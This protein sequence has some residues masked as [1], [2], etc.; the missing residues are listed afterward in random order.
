MCV[1]KGEHRPF[2]PTPSTIGKTTARFRRIEKTNFNLC[3]IKHLLWLRTLFVVRF[4]LL[5]MCWIF[6]TN[7]MPLPKHTSM[8]LNKTTNTLFKK[9]IYNHMRFI[10]R[11][12]DYLFIFI[13]MTT[14]VFFFSKKKRI[15][16]VV[17]CVDFSVAIFFCYG[18]CWL[19]YI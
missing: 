16:Y 1:L 17:K 5:K 19:Q 14:N 8:L 13:L 3:F 7:R 9:Y 15:P 10:L 12:T 11:K 2:Y 6:G 18:T 4:L